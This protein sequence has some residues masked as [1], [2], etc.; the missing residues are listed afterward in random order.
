MKIHL[1]V[2]S[3]FSYDYDMSIARIFQIYR[4]NYI[5]FTMLYIS[6]YIIINIFIYDIFLHIFSFFDIDINISL[7]KLNEK[8][9][10]NVLLIQINVLLIQIK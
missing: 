9:H 10:Q 3:M 5:Y 7:N 4:K 2:F 6:K 8:K 1:N